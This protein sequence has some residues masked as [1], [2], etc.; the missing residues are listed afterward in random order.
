M[1]NTY[2]TFSFS[3]FLSLIVSLFGS[4]VSISHLKKKHSYLFFFKTC[5]S[6]ISDIFH[7]DVTSIF[8]FQGV[9]SC[10]SCCNFIT[11][12]WPILNCYKYSSQCF[13]ILA[14]T[15]KLQFLVE[16][17]CSFIFVFFFLSALFISYLSFSH[18]MFF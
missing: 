16:C 3:P 13:H 10:E 1:W 4:Y 14:N 8:T 6:I 17:V 5:L 9:I 18:C 15:F 7:R 12:H 11:C 2:S